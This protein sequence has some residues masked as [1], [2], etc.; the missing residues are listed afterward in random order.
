MTY[1]NP[2]QIEG[3]NVGD[4]NPLKE[5]FVLLAAITVISFIVVMLLAGVA[6]R[7]AIY[8]PFETEQRIAESLPDLWQPENAGDDTDSKFSQERVNREAYLRDLGNR[9]GTAMGV[10][11]PM[12]VVIHYSEAPTVNAFAM[13]GG[14]IVIYAGL[15]NKLPSE[16]AVAMVLAHEIAHVKLRHP[17]VAMSRG[18]TVSIALGAL[19]GLTDNDAAAQLV[20][21]LGIT[22]TLSF[23]RSQEHAADALAADTLI[24]LYGHLEGADELYRALKLEYTQGTLGVVNGSP[25]FLNTHP[26]LDERLQRLAKKSTEHGVTGDITPL[27][28]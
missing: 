6:Q 17:I 20:Q 23:S 25:E 22:T 7:L 24:K 28:W 26:D 27:G 21:W 14:Q 16:N 15:A 12:T 10:S 18:V 4:E 13:L 3:I 1:E 5:L 19:F 11:E 9:L 2:K 8:I